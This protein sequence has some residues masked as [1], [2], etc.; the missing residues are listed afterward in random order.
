MG[1]G[2]NGAAGNGAAGNGRQ[3]LSLKLRAGTK[4]DGTAKKRA[5]DGGNNRWH[6][7]WLDAKKISG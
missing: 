7:Y 1:R 5:G 6:G 4:T 2:Y 3:M